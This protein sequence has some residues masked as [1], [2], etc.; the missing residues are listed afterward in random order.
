MPCPL[1]SCLTPSS[2]FSNGPRVS[3]DV[4]I[5]GASEAVCAVA[6]ANEVRKKAAANQ[7]MGRN[8]RPSER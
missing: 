4:S 1:A 3:M 6:S 8:L 2:H 7:R 5:T